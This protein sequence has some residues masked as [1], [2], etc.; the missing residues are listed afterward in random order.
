[1][2]EKT[3]LIQGQALRKHFKTLFNFEGP[4]RLSLDARLA[5]KLAGSGKLREAGQKWPAP[6]AREAKRK[7]AFKRK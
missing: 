7:R 4:S 3:D 1:M 2:V 6:E 5:R